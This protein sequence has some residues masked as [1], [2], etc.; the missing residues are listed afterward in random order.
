MPTGARAS[1]RGG[2]RFVRSLGSRPRARARSSWPRT[3]SPRIIDRTPLPRSAS[4]PLRGSRDRGAAAD[5]DD[6]RRARR[7]RAGARAARRPSAPTSRSWP[8]C[9]R[10]PRAA[11]RIRSDLGELQ[12]LLVRVLETRASA[13]AR[14]GELARGGGAAGRGLR[15]DP[16]R[17]RRRA[18][19]RRPAEDGR[20]PGHRPPGPGAARPLARRR[21]SPSSAATATRSRSRWST[22]TG[23]A[24]STT[25]TGARRGDRMLV[26]V[27][28]I[29]RRQLRDV[30]RAFRLEEDEF[31][32]VA[33]HTDADGLATMAQRVAELIAG[34]QTA[35]GPADRDRR[36]GRRAARPTGSAPSGCSRAP[37]RR[38]TRRRPP[39]RRWRAAPTAPH[40]ALARSVAQAREKLVRVAQNLL[41]FRAASAEELQG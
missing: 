14:T 30:D 6:L 33:P 38:P 31:A 11:A 10:V 5:R 17:G 19:R 23:S 37:P 34:S 7:A 4:C 21:C 28:A 13:P 9:A 27:A 26:A 2:G 35:D 3:G 41:K 29:L 15:L 8:R 25:P 24:G 1:L 12:A 32:I 20:R 39:G 36:R 18:G 40:A 16:R 22:S